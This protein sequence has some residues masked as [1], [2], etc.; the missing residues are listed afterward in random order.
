M[1]K[2]K[3]LTAFGTRPEVI[4]LA[5]FI[6]VVEADQGCVNVTCAT[7]QHREMQNDV[8][9]TFGLK[10]AYDLDIMRDGQDLFYLTDMVLKKMQPVL[11]EV[12]PD[13]LVVQGDTTTAFASALCGYYA[14]IPVVH[15]E[16]GLR[17][18]NIY[19]PYPE[20]ANRQLISRLATLHMAPT[21]IAIENLAK[22]GIMKHV[23]K[24][25]NTIVDAVQYFLQ[26]EKAQDSKNILVT[27][28]RRENFGKNL[29]HICFAIAELSKIY[30][31]YKFIWPVHPNPNIKQY[32]EQNMGGIDNIK[33]IEP[34]GY[35]EMLGLINSSCLILSDSGGIQ[36]ESCILGK[37]IIILREET[38]RHEVVESGVGVLVGANETK[39]IKAVSEHFANLKPVNAYQRVYGT[40]GVS[41]RILDKIKEHF[42]NNAYE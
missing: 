34:L 35:Q 28:H 4:K 40:P 2:I 13:Y 26:P 6:K 42:K 24:V 23:F 5:P 21:D 37:R 27:V 30:N 15:I 38:E 3:I 33:L 8:M 1:R 7:T 25:G 29:Q 20:E 22:E 18:R 17:T 10:A 16:A 9:E 41:Q 31:E 14:K 11:Q 36:E 19:N 39:I 32:V 12:A